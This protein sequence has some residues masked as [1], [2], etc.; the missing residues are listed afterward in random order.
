MPMPDG[1]RG[2]SG[3]S[4]AQWVTRL[5][6]LMGVLAVGVSAQVTGFT[7]VTAAAG[8]AST[9]TAVAYTSTDVTPGVGVGD[10]D[11]NGYQDIFVLNGYAAANHLYMNNGDGTFTESAAA[12]GADQVFAGSG[13]AVGD[14]NGDGWLDVYVTSLGQIPDL[15]GIHRLYRNNGGTGFQNVATA[16]G[17]QSEALP[18]S[19]YGAV[20]GDIDLDGD[21][22]LFRSGW[23]GWGSLGNR[24]YRNDGTHFTE[25]TFTNFPGFGYTLTKG[26]APL[27]VDMDGDRD[28]D[29]LLV[30]DFVTSKYFENI[31]GGMFQD[32]TA[33]SGTSLET[34][35]MGSCVGDFDNDGIFDW[36]V[37]SIWREGPGYPGTGNMLY[38]GLGGHV[39]EEIGEAAGVQ[40][41]GWG[42][43]VVAFDFDHDGRLDIAENNGWHRDGETEFLFEQAYL[44]RNDGDM[45]FTEMAVALGLDYALDGR[46]LAQLDYDN[47]GDMDLVFSG[48]EHPV[49]LFRNDTSGPDAHWLKAF[50]DADGQPGVAPDGYGALVTLDAPG[51]PRQMRHVDGGASYLSQSELSA[52]FGLGST[53]AAARLVVRWPDGHVQT[54]SDLPA[55]A[56]Y[57][58]VCCGPWEDIGFALS[59]ASGAPELLGEGELAGNDPIDLHLSNVPASTTAWMVLGLAQAN[60]AFYGGTLVPTLAPPALQLPLPTSP[61][62]AL[63][64]GGLWPTGVPAG[65]QVFFQYWVVDATGPFGLTASN[66]L[67]ATTP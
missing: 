63:S 4:R 60:I 45:Q 39:F 17:V 12:W 28:L 29:L 37:T 57:T 18:A 62:G 67:K 31:G 53:T 2:R 7:D 21:L 54:L 5:P 9:H 11:R 41:G 27:L 10:F 1:N 47:D 30:A 61:A 36:Y 50:L 15:I 42:W 64:V 35:G 6:V 38:R 26:Y 59:G 14:Y 51:H 46:G 48:T 13:L 25:L 43:G 24:L 40:D 3:S 56:S 23:T 32:V 55:D 8:I 58:I 49:K 22:D 33:A 34:A 16:M 52:H 65:L 19:S 20:W 66:A 44:W